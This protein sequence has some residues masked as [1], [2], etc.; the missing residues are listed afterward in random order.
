MRA[1]L[2][3]G[4][5]RGR[6]NAKRSL[7]NSEIN[8]AT[9]REFAIKLQGNVLFAR[10]AQLPRLKI[11]DLRDFNVGAEHNVLEIFDD[12]Q[13]AEPFEDD[14]VKQAI[15][16]DSMFK[17]RE[18]PSVK[19]PVSNENKRSFFHRRMFRLD[20]QL[21]RL[22]CR[23]VRCGDEIAQ[24]TEAAFERQAGFFHHLRVQAHPGELDKVGLGRRDAVRRALRRGSRRQA[25]DR[26]QRA[27]Q[28]EADDHAETYLHV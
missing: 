8:R 15:I 11:F 21:W 27:E 5:G 7:S 23:N 14:Y 4:S 19:S 16:G 25:R 20:E 24:R 3:S 2:R 1:A 22:P 6:Q 12:F 10:Y 13:I 26:E 28:R 9:A 17:K 18:G